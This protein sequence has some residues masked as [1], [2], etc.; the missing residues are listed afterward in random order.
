MADIV[1][2]LSFISGFL[3]TEIVDLTAVFNLEEKV[4]LRG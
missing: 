4:V 2:H 3:E 1:A